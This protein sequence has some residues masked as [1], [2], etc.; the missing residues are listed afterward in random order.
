MDES[1]HEAGETTPRARILSFPA[2][3]RPAPRLIL[4]DEPGRPN[5]DVVRGRLNAA[6]YQV[7]RWS[8]EPATGYPP[9]VHIYPELLWLISGSLTVL[10]TAERKL[11][12]LAPGD[13]IEI[14]PGLVHGTMAGADGALYLL[15]TR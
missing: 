14:P 8:S 15:A 12:E 3:T 11:L 10:L 9:H 1:M 4:W 2:P 13:R 7:V 6:G 5:E